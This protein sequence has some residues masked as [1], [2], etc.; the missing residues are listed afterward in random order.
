MALKL[1][2]FRDQ[3]LLWRDQNISQAEMI[4]R[5]AAEHSMPVTKPTLSSFLAT[6]DPPSSSMPSDTLHRADDAETAGIQ[7]TDMQAQIHSLTHEMGEMKTAITETAAHLASCRDAIMQL[8]QEQRG[9]SA[10]IPRPAEQK[11]EPPPD[12]DATA[13]QR[14]YAQTALREDASSSSEI[15]ETEQKEKPSETFDQPEQIN[16]APAPIRGRRHVWIWLIGLVVVAATIVG[17]T[18]TH[19]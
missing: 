3:I 1:A 13:W 9:L 5:L 19:S 10:I 14:F 7:L 8:A 11:P 12:D 4:R 15:P 6:L 2:P 18:S 17:Y 16:H